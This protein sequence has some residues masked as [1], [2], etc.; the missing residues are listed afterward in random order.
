V[1][2]ET[3]RGKNSVK[4]LGEL[5]SGFICCG[6]RGGVLCFLST[7]TEGS[8]LECCCCRKLA[9]AFALVRE[10]KRKEEI[11][12]K[13]C[14]NMEKH[15]GSKLLLFYGKQGA[16]DSPSNY[17]EDLNQAL[18]KEK[19]KHKIPRRVPRDTEAEKKTG[20]DKKARPSGNRSRGKKCCRKNRK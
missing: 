8:W 14:G 12:L 4:A 5:A 15:R 1:V 18:Q 6:G 16:G 3:L 13:D 17:K 10:T 7:A 19:K 2:G 9:Q 11:R 20:T